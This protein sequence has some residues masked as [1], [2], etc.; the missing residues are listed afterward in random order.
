MIFLVAQLILAER[1]VEPGELLVDVGQP[2]LVRG[3]E[4]G[5]LAREISVDDP[6]ETLLLGEKPELSRVW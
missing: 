4:R 1:G 2:G 5:A 6:N 3:A